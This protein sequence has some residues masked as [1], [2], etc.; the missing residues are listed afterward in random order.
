MSAQQQRIFASIAGPELE[1]MGYEVG[2]A[3]PPLGVKARAYAAHDVGMRVVNFV[4]LRLVR[5]RGREVGYVL[6]RKL[7]GAWR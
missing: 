1:R 4:R 7:A 6:K 5:E 2:E 3:A